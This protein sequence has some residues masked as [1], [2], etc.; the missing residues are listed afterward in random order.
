MYHL[1]HLIFNYL[2]IFSYPLYKKC[3]F[4]YKNLS[5]RKKKK[6]IAKYLTSGMN[7]LDIGANIGYYTQY[8]SE[9]VGNSGLVY[10]FEPDTK[11]FKYL[12]ATIKNN[13]NVIPINKAVGEASKKVKLYTSKELNVDHQTY[14]SGE[15]RE[16]IEIEM[17]AIDDLLAD[18][19]HSI[20]FI[21]LDI[22]GYDY[23]AVK[24]MEKMIRHSEKIG[25]FGEFSPY[26]LNKAGVN[27]NDYILLLK[28]LGFE[29]TV[30]GLEKEE[31][32]DKYINEKTFYTDFWAIKN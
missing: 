16:T 7:V 20:D 5:D 27:P 9:I 2:Y 24:G 11:N 19:N 32:F 12:E 14:D 30:F 3:Y 28:E 31:N 17:L 6:L 8:F 10:A 1:F 21:K 18:K 25:I 29:V 22:Q 4:L 26:S 13:K 23:Y 15:N